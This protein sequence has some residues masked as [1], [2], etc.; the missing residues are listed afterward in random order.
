MSRPFLQKS[1]VLV[2]VFRNVILWLFLVVLGLLD[3][4]FGLRLGKEAKLKRQ[5]P[6]AVISNI[7]EHTESH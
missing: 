2:P 6:S 7:Q 1:Q 4:V 5:Q 3:Y